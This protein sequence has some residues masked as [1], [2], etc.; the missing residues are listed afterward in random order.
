MNDRKGV[1]LPMIKNIAAIGL[2]AVVVAT[3][4]CAGQSAITQ[5]PV[6]VSK[7]IN[8]L[9]RSEC[10]CGGVET[11]KQFKKRKKAEAAAQPAR[12]NENGK[13]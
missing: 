2:L 8:G 1:D 6:W 12:S 3:S 7:G 10:K 13:D 11:Q 4:G 5:T 9:Q